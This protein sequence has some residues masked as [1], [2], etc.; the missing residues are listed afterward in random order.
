M[1]TAKCQVPNASRYPQ[2][3]S[4]QSSVLAFA[5]PAFAREWHITRFVSNVTVAQD[6]TMTV[7][8]HLVV[9]FDGEYHGIYRDIPIEYPGPHGTN[10]KLF[11]KVTG[12][13][14]AS[15]HKLKYD[16]SVQNG[17][18]HLKIYIPDAST[19]RRPS[20]SITTSQNGVRWFDGYDE[21]YWNVTG[22]DWPVPIDSAVDD[23]SVSAER[24]GQSARA[25]LH[26]HVRLAGAGRD[27]GG[28]WQRGAGADQRSALD[29]REGLTADVMISKGVLNEPSKL[30]F[31]MWFIRSN[32]IVL[33]PLW[34]FIVMFFFWWT[35]G[36]DPKADISVAPMYEPPK[37]MTPAEV[38]ALI[39]DS[40]HPRDIT[41]TLVDLAVKGYVKI[42]E[43]ESKVLLFTHRDYIFHS[44]KDP[45]TWTPDVAGSAR[46]CDAE[47]PVPQRA[48]PDSAV[49]LAQPVL[50]RHPHHQ[51]RHSRRTEEQGH[52]LG[53]SRFRACL[54]A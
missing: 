54:R 9:E 8:E 21:L 41:S 25:G 17:N 29:M 44:L 30:T 32:T 36:R 53:R 37:D 23:H 24:G 5:T 27:R 28:E 42:E 47:S 3:L 51:G 6:G 43:T 18:R 50:R 1:L 40:V 2:I 35:K 12:V 48:D 11:L 15:G 49:G 46:A 52:V 26:R 38:G 16:S 45:G 20:R 39:D 34:A 22:N 33:L 4:P 14:D 10:Y 19:A 13:T 7:R 31:A